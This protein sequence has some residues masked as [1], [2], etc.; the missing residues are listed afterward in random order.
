MV[1]KTPK[2]PEIATIPGVS[3]GEHPARLG[4]GGLCLGGGAL[5]R[6]GG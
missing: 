1:V 5:A 6:L 3:A 4:G 2:M